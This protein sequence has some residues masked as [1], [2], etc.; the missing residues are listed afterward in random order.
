MALIIEGKMPKQCWSMRTVDGET[1][2]TFCP[3]FTGCKSKLPY[4]VDYRPSDCPIKGE[5]PDN[6]EQLIADGYTAEKR[7]EEMEKLMQ[8]IISTPVVY[9]LADSL[10]A[11]PPGATYMKE[12]KRR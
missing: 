9:V 8:R 4:D 6:Y 5:I 11:V 1:I 2:R 10:D 3:L 7:K 12:V